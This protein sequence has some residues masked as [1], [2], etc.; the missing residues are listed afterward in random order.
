MEFEEYFETRRAAV[1]SYLAEYMERSEVGNDT[2]REAMKHTLFSGGKRFR[3]TLAIAAA[4]V[5]DKG[6]E[7]VMPAACAL[8]LIHTY[9][10][11]HDDL[12]SMDDD[13]FRR[14][15]PTSHKVFGE[16]MAILAGD[17]LLTAAF[18]LIARNRKVPGV[19]DSQVLDVVSDVAR[20]CGAAGMVGG[21]AIDIESTGVELDSEHIETLDRLKTGALIGVSARIGA[22]LAG[23]S[24]P[25][26]D[27]MMR[28]GQCLGI[29]FQ[30]S[31]DVLD[32]VGDESK[33][34][35]R[36]RKDAE[37]KKN[38]LVRVLGLDGARERAAQ[39]IGE[40]KRALEPFG[41]KAL[42]LADLA[43]LVVNRE[44]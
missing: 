6:M 15:K 28:Y 1:E 24:K 37:N 26:V 40:A 10:L 16:A 14:G 18:D 30:I 29:A 4:E 20:A 36:L 38:S 23:V 42:M 11:V 8:E 12:P 2:L 25:D 7:T 22:V 27:S 9:S 21:Q 44:S 35:K 39:Y 19:T 5:F 3:P 17:A 33:M 31:D 13:D 43:D 34:G 41:D 32:A